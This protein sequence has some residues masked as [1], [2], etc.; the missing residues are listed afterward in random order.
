[1][2]N[3]ENKGTNFGTPLKCV[4]LAAAVYTKLS[5]P[6]RHYA[7]SSGV[8]FNLH[9][10]IV[11]FHENPRNGLVADTG[12]GPTDTQT[13]R[14]GPHTTQSSFRKTSQFCSF[15]PSCYVTGK[16]NR[17]SLTCKF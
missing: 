5:F 12:N 8:K 7:D 17:S 16:C 15:A 11:G 14:Y 6:Q 4:V 13:D 3:V 2:K 10:S 1:M 9:R